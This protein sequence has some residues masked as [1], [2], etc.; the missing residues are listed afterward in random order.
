[1]KKI[2]GN[3]VARMAGFLSYKELGEPN[4]KVL[5][6]FVDDDQLRVMTVG[7]R[8]FYEASVARELVAT[9]RGKVPDGFVSARDYS[10]K[11]GFVGGYG[12]SACQAGK[13]PSAVQLIVGRRRAA[14]FAPVKEL[15]AYFNRDKSA[16]KGA[17]AAKAKILVG[18]V[19]VPR[20]RPAVTVATSAI[21]RLEQI[22]QN[23]IS[24]VER[25]EAVLGT[26]AAPAPAKSADI[27]IT[28]PDLGRIR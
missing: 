23:L 3:E 5:D 21:E 2:N 4:S 6:R 20:P 11:K 17:A 8:K 1:M 14:W 15:D 16:A 19:A 10:V 28:A 27:V 24:I 13:I 18:E 7:T 9:R 26:S 12:P 25:F 22:S